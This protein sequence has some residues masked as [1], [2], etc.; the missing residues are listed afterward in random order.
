MPV[1]DT[2][3]RPR[4]EGDEIYWGRQLDARQA[5]VAEGSGVRWYYL[6]ALLGSPANWAR[7]MWGHVAAAVSGAVLLPCEASKQLTSK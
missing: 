6:F 4:K 7:S 2:V 1:Q 3:T 5:L